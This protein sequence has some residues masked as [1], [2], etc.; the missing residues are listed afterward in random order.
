MTDT[1]QAP[2]VPGNETA[3]VPSTEAPRPADYNGA[4]RD[5]LVAA[6]SEATGEAAETPATEAPAPTEE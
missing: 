6:L 5:E 3:A 1:T 2:H 4:S